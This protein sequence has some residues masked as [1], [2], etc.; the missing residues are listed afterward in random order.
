MALAQSTIKGGCWLRCWALYRSSWIFAICSFLPLRL[1]KTLPQRVRQTTGGCNITNQHCVM[2]RDT[3]AAINTEWASTTGAQKGIKLKAALC[4]TLLQLPHLQ[5]PFQTVH[6]PGE[7]PLNVYTAPNTHW[8]VNRN[9]GACKYPIVTLALPSIITGG[10]PTH[11]WG[12]ICWTKSFKENT[13]KHW[14][15]GWNPLSGENG[16]IKPKGSPG[17]ERPLGKGS[18]V[19]WIWQ[20]AVPLQWGAALAGRHPTVLPRTHCNQQE[21]AISLRDGERPGKDKKKKYPQVYWGC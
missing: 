20:K 18:L 5:K 3:P 9:K 12:L 21:T 14:K 19:A 4:D 8:V 11:G 17:S 7:E 10:I 2:C 15:L 16:H 13:P 6:S 1:N